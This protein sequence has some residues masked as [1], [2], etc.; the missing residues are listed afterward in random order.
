MNIIDYYTEKWNFEAK[1]F[2]HSDTIEKKLAVRIGISAIDEKLAAKRYTKPQKIK[3]FVGKSDKASYNFRK[4]IE[5]PYTILLLND[6]Y[7][8]AQL[9][10]E[11]ILLNYEFMHAKAATKN[12]DFVIPIQESIKKLHSKCEFDDSRKD[13]FSDLVTICQ[14]YKENYMILNQYPDSLASAVLGRIHRKSELIQKF[15]MDSIQDCAL[16]VPFSYMPSS[17]EIEIEVFRTDLKFLAVNVIWLVQREYVFVHVDGLSSEI[18]VVDHQTCD[19]I[20][21]VKLHAKATHLQVLINSID[22]KGEK[23]MKSLGNFNGGIVYISTGIVYFKSF[24][25][26]SEIIVYRT[27]GDVVQM[28]LLSQLHVLVRYESGFEVLNIKSKKVVFKKTTDVKTH[29]M[30]SNLKDSMAYTSMF[31]AIDERYFVFG[32]SNKHV[33]VYRFSLSTQVFELLCET[34]VQFSYEIYSDETMYE[35]Y[36]IYDQSLLI[37]NLLTNKISKN[38][39]VRFAVGDTEKSAIR[40]VK[41]KRNG[42][43][44]IINIDEKFLQ[45]NNENK[46]YIIFTMS[47]LYGNR[48]LLEDTYPY[49]F[50]NDLNLTCVDLGMLGW[51]TVS[52]S[53]K[54]LFLIDTMKSIK[55]VKGTDPVYLINENNFIMV[56]WVSLELYVILDNEIKFLSSFPLPDLNNKTCIRR[57]DFK[58]ERKL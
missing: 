22:E 26:T 10:E 5:L 21:N 2:K 33:E 14:I 57:Y 12:I 1:P 41:V 18:H 25:Q 55:L 35:E 29:F 38:E 23:L 20:G 42:S 6:K 39:N 17:N 56:R 51:C 49:S 53:L 46:E 16:I 34:I 19:D 50:K 24:D 40:L 27:S 52:F 44:K 8:Q 15:A 54:L 4:L 3:F 48:L 47:G 7:K 37:D 45:I 31:D 28:V 9:L 36:C 30:I 32:L 43:F 58:V 11:L 13:R